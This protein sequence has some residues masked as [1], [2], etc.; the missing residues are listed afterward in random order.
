MAHSP[1]FED[2]YALGLAEAVTK[3]PDLAVNENDV[4]DFLL[5]AASAMAEKVVQQGAEDKRDLYVDGAT[6]EELTKLADDRYG[7]TRQPATPAQ[8]TLS[9]TR[10]SGGGGGT[11]SAGTEVATVLDAQG[12]DVRFVTDNDL[13]FAAAENGPKTIGATALVSGTEGNVEASTITRIIDTVFDSTFS[14]NNAAVA[15]GGN[16][17]EDDTSVRERIR[18]RPSSLRRATVAALEFGAKQVA[19]VRVARATEDTATGQVT[20][21]VSD[22]SGSS[23]AEMV[24]DVILELENWRAAGIP[25]SVVGGV[26]LTADITVTLTLSAG[27]DVG[28][29]RPFVISAIEAE[30]NK[31][32]VGETLYDSMVIAAARNVDPANILDVT[33]GTVVGPTLDTAPGPNELIRPG[34]ITVL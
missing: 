13:V 6:G 27:G 15:A 9:W 22:S 16:D 1:N 28:T 19:T 5:S 33:I 26:V 14:V 8:V 2:L 34:T 4:S 32:S 23:N 10:T 30:I 21:A 25:V 3:R 31:L 24:N 18:E 17:E 29:L 11:I 20:V 12:N 7:I